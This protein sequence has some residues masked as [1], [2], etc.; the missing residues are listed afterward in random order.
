MGL[1]DLTSEGTDQVGP[2]RPNRDSGILMGT[3]G[4]TGLRKMQNIYNLDLTHT[5]LT[6]E[7]VAF[8]HCLGRFERL[9]IWIVGDIADYP[10]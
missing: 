8:L 9:T 5:H 3:E 10:L 1:V 4:L 7:S 6:K 2:H